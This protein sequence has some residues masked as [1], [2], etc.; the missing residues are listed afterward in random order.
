MKTI[1]HP[2]VSSLNYQRSIFTRKVSSFNNFNQKSHPTLSYI[3]NF[4]NQDCHLNR[5]NPRQLITIRNYSSNKISGPL[6]YKA[7]FI[8]SD[9]FSLPS[10]IALTRLLTPENVSVVVSHENNVIGKYAKGCKLE[11]FHWKDFKTVEFND[12]IARRRDAGSGFDFGVVA[13]FGYLIPARV[14]DRFPL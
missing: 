6:S 1:F 5:L 7:V 13:S 10:L 12:E 11:M 3:P 2:R 8:G 4:Q 14:I 9:H